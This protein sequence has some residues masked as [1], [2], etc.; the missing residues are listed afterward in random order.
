MAALLA[1]VAV[2]AVTAVGEVY[3]QPSVPVLVGGVLLLAAAIVAPSR[4]LPLTA[5]L[6]ALLAG[7]TA[8][9]LLAAP[10]ANAPGS[11]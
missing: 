9:H 8:G 11:P 10:R 7:A 4:L 3:I 1:G 6:G 2:A 5:L